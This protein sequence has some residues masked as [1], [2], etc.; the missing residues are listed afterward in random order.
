MVDKKRTACGS[1]PVFRG[2]K[3]RRSQRGEKDEGRAKEARGKS[4]ETLE[5]IS[6]SNGGYMLLK[7]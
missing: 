3:T 1:I 2:G 5:T 6:R 7:R 4:G